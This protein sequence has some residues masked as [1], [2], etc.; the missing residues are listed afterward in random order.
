MADPKISEN[1][2][3]KAAQRLARADGKQ[4]G[5]LTMLERRNDVEKAKASL[6]RPTQGEQRHDG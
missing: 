4:L 6:E 5:R 1:T 3:Q 2:I